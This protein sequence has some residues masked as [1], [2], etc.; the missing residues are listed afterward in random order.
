MKFKRTLGSVTFDVTN[1][2]L[3]ILLSFIMIYPFVFVLS[4]SVSAPEAV[5]K[6][7]VKL[8]PKGF[9]FDAYE[10]V[11]RSSEIVRAYVNTINYTVTGTL[12]IL[13]FASFAA[14]PLSKSR[15]YGRKTVTFLFAL[16]MIIPGGMIPNFLLIKNL[17]LL[18]TMWAIVLPPIFNIWYIILI[19]TNFQSIPESL[20]ESAHIDGASEWRTLFQIVIPL[21]K[22]ILATIGL[23]ADVNHWNSFFHALL[24]LNDPKKFPLQIILRNVIQAE[25]Q[26]AGFTEMLIER[27][28]M[29]AGFVEKVKMATIAV[30]I[31]PIILVYPFA[32]KYFIKGALVGSIKG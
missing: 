16:T 24:Y 2:S 5:V 23:F 20:T 31:G 29:G 8:F 19:R 25:V 9:D 4:V 14:Y 30:A 27:G 3:M 21:S 17:G 18:D 13:L 11:F 1:I 6:G 7:W 15:F 26:T 32:Q 10:A 28:G 22:P 12:L